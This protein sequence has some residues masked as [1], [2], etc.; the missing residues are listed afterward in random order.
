MA[1]SGAE[2]PELVRLRER[3]SELKQLSA[4][5]YGSLVQIQKLVRPTGGRFSTEGADTYSDT[6]DGSRLIFDHTAVWACQMF[7]NG[8]SSYLVPRADQWAYLKM[9][10]TPSS[11]MNDAELLALQRMTDFLF[12]YLSLPKTRFYET[13]HEMFYDQG[14]YGTSVAMVEKTADRGLVFSACPLRHCFFDVDGYDSADTMYYRRYLRGSALMRKYPS[15]LEM[16]EFNKENRNTEY[17]VIYSVEPNPSPAAGKTS[18]GAGKAYKTTVWCPSFKQ[19]LDSGY[20]SAFPFLVSRWNT[21]A[22]D[23]WGRG[24]AHTCLASIEMVNKM[25]EIVVRAGELAIEPPMS[26]EVDSVLLPVKYGQRALLWRERGADPPTP[27]MSGTDPGI[28]LEMMGREQESIVRSFF[29]DQIMREQKRERQSVVEIQDERFQM[30][31]QLGPSVAREQ[32]EFLGPAISLVLSMM[33]FEKAVEDSGVEVPDS[34][35]GGEMEVVYTSPAAFAQFANRI[36]DMSGFIG[37]ITPL[38]QLAP[39]VLDSLDFHAMIEHYSR[40]RNQPRDVLRGKK[41]VE[42]IRKDRKEMEEMQAVT[43]MAPQAAGAI[44]DIAQ[45][46]AISADIPGP[47]FQ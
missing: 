6:G 34:L 10:G 13:C 3:Y 4:P 11:A 28:T 25:K 40:Y 5:V 27:V 41:D 43:Q 15:V 17:E 20:M 31:Q 32:S 37:D 46:E 24:P 35:K 16:A 12:H 38:G 18:L 21:Q 1:H 26:A 19:V 23:I 39:D 33:D 47:G 9:A 29:V 2:D 8:L 22:G 7:A 44:K 14:S 36:S 30:L 42:N 45:A